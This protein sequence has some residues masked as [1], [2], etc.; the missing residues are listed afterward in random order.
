MYRFKTPALLPKIFPSA[1]WKVNTPLK[2]VYLTFDDGPHPEITTWVLN[3]LSDYDAKA[4]FFCVGENVQRF[5]EIYSKIIHSGHGT[6]NHTFNHLNGWNTEVGKYV[7]NINDC[8]KYVNSNLFRPPYGRIT[9]LQ[10]RHLKN[11]FRIIMWTILSRDFEQNLDV[12]KS[13]R[14]I[15]RGTTNGSILVFHDS[16]KAFKNLK[17]LLPRVLSELSAQGYIFKSL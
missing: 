13:L 8:E 11:R 16:T 10:V 9:P 15:V 7:S 1:I 2:E 5:P 6:G 12:H 3:Q 14:E 17:Y 4:T